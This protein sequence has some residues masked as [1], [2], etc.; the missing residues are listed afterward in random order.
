MNAMEIFNLITTFIKFPRKFE[1]FYSNVRKNNVLLFSVMTGWPLS[2][3]TGARRDGIPRFRSSTRCFRSIYVRVRYLLADLICD[4]TAQSK[5]SEIGEQGRVPP[6]LE[7][8]NPRSK[9]EDAERENDN[10]VRPTCTCQTTG[11]LKSHL[12]PSGR[13]HWS[14]CCLA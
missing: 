9:L 7:Y 2:Q 13:R 14:Q 8:T 6:S 5:L 12:F 1:R 11:N 10:S 3:K 4:E